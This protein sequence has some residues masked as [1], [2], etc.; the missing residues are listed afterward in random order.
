MA[1]KKN[2][3][4]LNIRYDD[5]VKLIR[6]D[7]NKPE[8]VSLLN[9][10]I[11]ESTSEE[12]IRLYADASL[13]EFVDI[14]KADILHAVP[15]SDD[16][17]GGSQLW[18]KQS[19]SVNYNT[20]DAFS[21]GDM[22]NDYMGNMYS[23]NNTTMAPG[24]SL[25]CT[26]GPTLLTRNVIC[27]P[28]RFICPTPVS[29]LVICNQPITTT[30]PQLTRNGCP[31]P[32]LVDGCASALGCTI[33]RTTVINPA[34]IATKQFG[35]DDTVT[36][37]GN[38]YGSGEMYNDYMQNAYAPDANEAGTATIG[39]ATII[40]TSPVICRF[41]PATLTVQCR[42]SLLY[43]CITRNQRFCP[44]TC[45]FG[46]RYDFITSRCPINSLACATDFTIPNTT[47]AQT[48]TIGGGGIGRMDDTVTGFGNEY[49]T[50][51]MY[52][53]YMQND[54]AGETAGA[55]IDDTVVRP[56]IATNTVV[57]QV[58]PTFTVACQIT[59]VWNTRCCITQP[60]QSRCCPT[61]PFASRCCVSKYCPT[62]VAVCNRPTL[63][64][65]RQ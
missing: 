42:P 53:G 24:I 60:L 22:Y 6:P 61:V 8:P 47:V 4:G 58:Q 20:G 21:D 55:G 51:D 64:C 57:C 62:W 19:A 63:I 17:L 10:Y 23:P 30:L 56:N 2:E 44:V 29:R 65:N 40:N 14:A 28:T 41:G 34:T 32:S 16:P 46:T 13:T 5:F 50:G 12:K 3:E 9:G 38:E 1:T 54:Y 11:G 35:T 26:I 15:N 52:N 7:P 33:N 31:Q 36:G 37:F 27:R 43:V 39:A 59:Q 48:G 25:N 18:V 49:G 45:R